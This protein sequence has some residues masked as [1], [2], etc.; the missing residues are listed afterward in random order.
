M[1]QPYPVH[2]GVVIVNY[3]NGMKAWSLQSSGNDSLGLG[4]REV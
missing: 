1:Y 4:V 3:L 2:L